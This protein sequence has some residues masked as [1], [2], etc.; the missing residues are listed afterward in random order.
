MSEK[1]KTPWK[2]GF[3][4][5]EQFTAFLQKVDGNKVL[6]YSH[7]WL[8]FPDAEP[9]GPPTTRTYGDFGP[10]HEEVSKAWRCAYLSLKFDLKSE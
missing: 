8:D 10:A 5:N 2:N 1:S 7:M 6:Q 4:Y 3:Y 9:M